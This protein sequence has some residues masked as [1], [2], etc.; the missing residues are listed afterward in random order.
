MLVWMNGLG[1]AREL[2]MC[3]SAAKWTTAS[4]VPTRSWM[5]AWSVM[6]PTTR[7]TRLSGRPASASRDAAY[8]IL[9]SQ[10]TRASVCATTW[11]TRCEE[12]TSELQSLMRNSTDEYCVKT[13]T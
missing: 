1:S 7:S 6:S 8:V 10:V 5:S 12:H 2:S 13:K 4:D 3:D 11:W 9:S